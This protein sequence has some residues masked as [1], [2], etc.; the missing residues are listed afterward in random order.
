[1][2][3]Q[4]GWHGSAPN[5]EQ[6]AVAMEETGKGRVKRCVRS[7]NVSQLVKVMVMPW[8]SWELNMKILSCWMQT[9][10]Q[11]LKPVYLKRFFRNAILTAVLQRPI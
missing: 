2:E 6:Y 11:R 9:L 4:V 10:Q 7:K 5:D 1:M 3:N 8:Q